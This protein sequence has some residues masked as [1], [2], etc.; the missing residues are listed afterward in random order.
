M[1][2][3]VSGE[4]HSGMQPHARLH[5]DCVMFTFPFKLTLPIIVTPIAIFP[6]K[7][8]SSMHITPVFT[9]FQKSLKKNSGPTIHQFGKL[10]AV[11]HMLS[12]N[13]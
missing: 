1:A 3:I 2:V 12:L 6:P 5:F 11:F 13:L 9:Y 4:S 10:V 8:E 7:I